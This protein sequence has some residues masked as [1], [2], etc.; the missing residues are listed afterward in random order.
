MNFLANSYFILQISHAKSFEM[1]HTRCLYSNH[2]QV[3]FQNAPKKA[4][5]GFTRFANFVSFQ[6][7]MKSN[8]PAFLWI[9]IGQI[10]VPA[11]SKP[12]SKGLGMKNLLYEIIICQKFKLKPRWQCQVA[13]IF[14]N[15]VNF[16]KIHEKLLSSIYMNIFR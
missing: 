1:M 13:L 8:F 5:H 10:T 6:K 14:P 3:Y 7:P 15:F 9:S 16:Q 12:H 2:I 11:S 4:F